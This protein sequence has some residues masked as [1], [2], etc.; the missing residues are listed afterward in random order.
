MYEECQT[1]SCHYKPTQADDVTIIAKEGHRVITVAYKVLATRWSRTVEEF[2]L[3]SRLSSC[4]T[5]QT[6]TTLP[7]SGK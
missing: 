4:H 3:Y 6:D 7:E 2:V 5:Y 1:I